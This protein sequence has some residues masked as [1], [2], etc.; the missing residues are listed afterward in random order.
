[1]STPLRLLAPALLVLLPLL[2]HGAGS[3]LS[4]ALARV[5]L[6]PGSWSVVESVAVAST[7]D[8][9]VRVGP[10]GHSLVI[11]SASEL[12]VLTHD[13]SGGTYRLERHL[14]S[15]PLPVH[16]E[17][18][19]DGSTLTLA[20][21]SAGKAVRI[22]WS[23]DAADVTSRE[24]TGAAKKATVVSSR[25][26]TRAAPAPTPGRA[27]GVGG[28]FFKAADSKKLR[29]W[30]SEQLGLNLGPGGFWIDI[31]WRELDEP[32]HVGHTVWAT[33]KKESKH[34]DGTFM[35]NYRVDQLDRLLE[36]LKAAGVKV[37]RTE[38]E[39]GN[40]RFAWIRDG[41]GNLVELWEP[42]GDS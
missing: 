8:A 4:P 42:P 36:K 5:P 12:D 3:P 11:E 18:T 6:Q 13:A 25:K 9:F 24:E 15:S 14:A 29:E 1:M 20:G 31:A 2:A 28:I 19:L 23:A 32:A 10:G 37:E 7:S 17:G 39:P 41:E 21:K 33:F 40:G 16:L 34:F 38:D 26:W 35:I 30:Y 27:T 22:V